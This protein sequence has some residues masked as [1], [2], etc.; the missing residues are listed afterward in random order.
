MREH[1]STARFVMEGNGDITELALKLVKIA[2]L[3]DVELLMSG[4]LRVQLA[5]G[6]SS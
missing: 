6:D 3:A 2:C 5:C 1:A 4:G